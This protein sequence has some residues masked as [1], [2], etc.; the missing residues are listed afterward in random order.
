MKPIPAAF[1]GTWHISWMEL[2]GP[3][4]VDLDGP[5]ELRLNRNGQGTMRFIAVEADLD[6]E[7]AES[8]DIVEFSWEGTDDGDPRCGRGWVT[9]DGADGVQGRFCFHLGDA[10]AFKAIRSAPPSNLRQPSRKPRRRR[11]RG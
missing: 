9:L 6:C 8:G 5:A 4:V 11:T 3:D 10:S 2:W 7:P 1:V